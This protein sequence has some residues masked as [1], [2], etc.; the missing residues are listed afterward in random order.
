VGDK[1]RFWIGEE[2]QD[3]VLSKREAL[4]KGLFHYAFTKPI[5]DGVS[6]GTVIGFQSYAL[7]E[8]IVRNCVFEGNVG[9]AIVNFAENIVV[10]GCVFRDNAY[11]IKYG[12][13]HVSGA[14]ARNNIF[15]NN[16]CEDTSWIDIARRGQPST[17]VIHSL[18]RF[19][20]DPQ[21][22]QH[23][24]IT[25]N[26]FRNPHGM[27]EAVAIHVLNAADV[28][29]HGNVF[30]GFEQ[31]VLVDAATTRDIRIEPTP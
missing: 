23:I 2:P 26:T 27:K 3:R 15:R 17:M 4:G 7:D 21:Y 10:E 30:E 6:K 22:N 19:F 20:K 11:Q 31:D 1:I 9:S 28:D 25:G 8:G 24:E 5:P 14:F 18:S 29:I 12:A 13:N 16:L